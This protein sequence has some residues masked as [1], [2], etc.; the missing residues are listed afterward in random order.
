MV[1]ERSADVDEVN[2]AFREAASTRLGH[3]LQYSE[4][5]LVSADIV[6]N[7][8]SSIFDAPLTQAVGRQV[9][10]HGWYDNDWGSPTGSW[11]S[12]RGSAPPSEHVTSAP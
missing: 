1:L 3:Y 11:S 2:A 5:P 6:G 9:K 7:P 12:P 8:H 10:V 4:A